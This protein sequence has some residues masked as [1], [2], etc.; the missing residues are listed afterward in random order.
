MIHTK[1]GKLDFSN[2]KNFTLQKALLRMKKRQ[3]TGQKN[4]PANQVFD[5]KDL[6]SEYL[7]N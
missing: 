7:K 5:L 2:I 1:I 6:Y 4:I 3:A